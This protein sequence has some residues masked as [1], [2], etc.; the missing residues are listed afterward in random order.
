LSNFFKTN[1]ELKL[2]ERI[3]DLKRENEALKEANEKLLNSAFS[4][5]REREF[6]EKERTLKIQI[7][8]LEATLKSDVSEKGT[9]LDR[10]NNERDQYDKLSNEHREMQVKYYEMKQKYDDMNEKM[11][12]LSKESNVDFTEIEEALI[13][14]KERRANR[15]SDEFLNIVDSEKIKSNF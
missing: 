11:L 15:N 10:L 2:K 12:F 8:Q 1:P 3:E 9:I 7:A 14:V 13:I 5:E 4:L 6:R